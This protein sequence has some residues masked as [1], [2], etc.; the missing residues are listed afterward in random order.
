MS[1]LRSS[2]AFASAVLLLVGLLP[3]SA[4]AATTWRMNLYRSGGMV[5]QD[6]YYTACTAAAAM[7]MLN[8][9]AMAGDGGDRFRW[10]PY[11]YHRTPDPRDYR[12]MTSILYFARAHDTLAAGRPGSDPHGWRNALNYYGWGSSAMTDPTKRV[13]DDLPY[14]SF[15]GALKG[16]VRAIARFRKPVGMLGWAGGHA[17]VITGYVV[18]GEDP[19]ISTNFTV[20]GLYLS[21]PLRSDAIVNK[22]LSRTSLLSGST[23]YRFQSYRETDSPLD[24]PYSAG[25]RRSSVASMSSE[26][27]RRWVIIAPIRNG[28]GTPIPPDPT[29]TPTPSPTPTPPPSPTPT[30]TQSPTPATSPPP[31]DPSPSATPVVEAPAA[32]AS[33]P[34]SATPA[35]PA[36]EAPAATSS[37]APS[38]APSQP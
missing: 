14:A 8:F 17:Q 28:L 35:V 20:N 7:M 29:P 32:P 12:D 27:Y 26:W 21:D 23:R 22:Y 5:Y 3:A 31:S 34:P 11:R 30:P 25:W 13:Y 4:G 16:A 10:T 1:R 24:D 36:S 2:L 9:T 6:P 38:A 15:D 33:Q 37:P 18:T 19:R